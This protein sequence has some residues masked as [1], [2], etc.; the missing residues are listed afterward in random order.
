[1]LFESWNKVYSYP[2]DMIP[3]IKE[4]GNSSDRITYLESE[5]NESYPMY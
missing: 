2:A 1:M 3:G 5:I 4:I